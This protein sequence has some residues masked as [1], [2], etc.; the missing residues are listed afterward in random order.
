MD[1]TAKYHQN[2]IDAFNGFYKIELE[3]D[4]EKNKKK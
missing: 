4:S 2:L 3:K 1:P